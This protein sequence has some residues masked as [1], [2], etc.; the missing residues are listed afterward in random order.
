MSCK[1]AALS[2][3]LLSQDGQ[4]FYTFVKSKE[5]SYVLTPYLHEVKDGELFP[6]LYKFQDGQ[7]FPYLHKVQ[8]MELF[9]FLG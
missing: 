5:W 3:L 6:Y 9:S 4:F 1:G 2:L 7:I 8:D